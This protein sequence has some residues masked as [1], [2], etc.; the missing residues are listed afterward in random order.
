MYMTTEQTSSADE[1]QMCLKSLKTH[2][3]TQMLKIDFGHKIFINRLASIKSSI[4]L[5][6]YNMKLEWKK[7]FC[8][9]CKVYQNA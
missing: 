2:L 9:I 3:H 7:S 1:E 4:T 6:D 5:W 8:N